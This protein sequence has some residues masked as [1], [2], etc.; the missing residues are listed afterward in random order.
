MSQLMNFIF[1]SRVAELF[2]LLGLTLTGCNVRPAPADPVVDSLKLTHATGPLPDAAFKAQLSFAYQFPEIVGANR[3]LNVNLLVKNLS[4]INWPCGGQLDGKYKVQ[5]GNR[6]LD[7]TGK[8]TEDAKGDLPYDL[9]PGDT[10][11]VFLVITT[12]ETPG[13]YTLEF[14]L[15]QEQV[16][17]FRDQGS[18]TLRVTLPV[19]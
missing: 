11:E 4:Q 7:N 10:A 3:R 2:I 16:T 12:P 8:P 14:D 1:R 5:V 6:W 17:W 15:V 18:A 19:Q 9:H 13:S